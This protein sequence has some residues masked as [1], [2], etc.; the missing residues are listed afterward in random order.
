[1]DNLPLEAVGQF[2][3]CAAKLNLIS[4]YPITPHLHSRCFA[5]GS[6]AHLRT[7]FYSPAAAAELD[8][9]DPACIATRLQQQARH[10]RGHSD[11]ASHYPRSCHERTATPDAGRTGSRYPRCFHQAKLAMRH[12]CVSSD[13]GVSPGPASEKYRPWMRDHS[14]SIRTIEAWRNATMDLGLGH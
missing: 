13:V 11:R 2:L 9:A 3:G 5:R 6:G 7:R 4:A 10:V 1:M 12:V 14:T 8:P